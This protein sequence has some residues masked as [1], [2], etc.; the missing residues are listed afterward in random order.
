MF[1]HEK[2]SVDSLEQRLLTAESIIARQRGIQAELLVG[3]ES[4]QVANMDG[5]RSMTEWVA[6][7]LDEDPQTAR[8]LLALSRATDASSQTASDLS[9]GLISF[10]R[11]AAEARL[12]ELGASAE[13]VTNSRGL[14]LSGL[15]R[16]IA[17][18]RRI[19]PSEEQRTFSE[20]YLALQPNLDASSWRLWGQQ[21][22]RRGGGG[23][24]PPSEAM[25]SPAF[26]RPEDRY[27]S[28]T[29]ML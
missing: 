10:P 11:A 13:V 6:S 7:R 3:L 21:G 16:L 12:S 25:P 20:R 1:D 24:G 15:W 29:Q 2:Q 4:A 19:S 9:A 5:C 28:A 17:R 23:T 8:G 14:D 18:H 27:R 22:N 26:Q